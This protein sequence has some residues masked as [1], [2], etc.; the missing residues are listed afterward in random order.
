MMNRGEKM[1]EEKKEEEVVE[2]TV[3]NQEETV[4]TTDSKE[5]SL[6]SQMAKLQEEVNTW[7]T[8]Y[9]KVFADMENLKRRLE[10]EH[11]NSLKFMMQSFIEELLPL[12]V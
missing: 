2:E 7:K 8:D 10:K 4:E 5:E 3:D 6:E 1:A 11:Q 12:V 9:Y